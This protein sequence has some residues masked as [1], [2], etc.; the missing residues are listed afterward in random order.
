MKKV[1]M[2]NLALVFFFASF[3]LAGRIE[4]ETRQIDIEGANNLDVELEFGAGE[5]RISPADMSQAATLDIRYDT[6]QVE[7]DV[8]YKVS[9]GIGHLYIKSEHRKHCDIDTDKNKLDLVLST[10]YPTSLK[11]DIGACDAEIDLGGIPLERLEIDVGAASGDI[12]F[13][14][15]NPRRLSEINIDAGATSLDMHSIGNANFELMTFSGGVGSFDLDFRGEY[16]GESKIDLEVG[17]GSADII[18]P[19][20]I[21]TRVETNGSNWLSSVDF[22]KD[23]LEEINDGIYESPDFE[24][25]ET[26][27]ILMLDV[28]LGSVD[29]YWKR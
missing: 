27:I 15:P 29:I 7:Y 23:D 3:A 2:V 17:L 19:R 14:K 6:R 1:L 13:S 20:G 18:L 12:D 5:L 21:P 24:D 16:K 25:S 8:D 22:H 11:M 26:R 9:K 28:G 4:H 10:R